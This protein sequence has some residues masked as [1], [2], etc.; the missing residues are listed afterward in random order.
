M[1]LSRVSR[2]SCEADLGLGVVA[3]RRLDDRR[4]R[5]GHVVD[6]DHLVGV[7]ELGV[8]QLEEV[9]AHVDGGA[10]VDLLVVGAVRSSNSCGRG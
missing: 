4:G 8:D 6:L 5:A 3:G 2:T 10:Q 9:L 1:I 7:A